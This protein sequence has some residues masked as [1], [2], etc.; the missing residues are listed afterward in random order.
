MMQ[1][2]SEKINFQG[3]L[4][5]TLSA[6]LNKP[7]GTAPRFYTLYVPCFTCTKDIR[8][9]FR[10]AAR[11]ADYGIGVL[12][13]DLTGLG[14]SDGNFADTTFSSNVDDILCAIDYLNQHAMIPSMIIGHSL[15]GTAALAVTHLTKSIKAVVTINSPHEPIHVQRHFKRLDD[16]LQNKGETDVTIAGQSYTLRKPFFDDLPRH[17]MDKVIR[18]LNAALLVLHAPNDDMVN[19]NN[20][21]SI[22]AKAVHPK[23][24]IAL[25]RM[26]HLLMQLDDAEYVASLINTWS[27]RYL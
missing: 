19:I 12:R 23:S 7:L 27:T 24:F 21:S 8:I 15:G 26:D 14:E 25:D 20:A 10:L 16:D 5:Y 17:D 2:S 22:F 11:L 4:G 3:S 18:Q 1:S 13:L 9:A 6:R